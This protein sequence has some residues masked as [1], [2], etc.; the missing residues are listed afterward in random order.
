[1]RDGIIGAAGTG[2]TI[3]LQEVSLWLSIICATLTISH[4]A[5]LFYGKWKN[6][7]K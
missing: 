3:I 5:M 6:R 2:G 7:D 4:F 1:M